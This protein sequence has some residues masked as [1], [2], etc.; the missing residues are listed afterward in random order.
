MTKFRKKPIVIEAFKWTGDFDQIE[1][2]EWAIKAIE[3]GIIY[4]IN[5]G[6][7]N[8]QMFII[9]SGTSNCQMFINTLEGVHE[10]SQGDWVIQGVKGELYPCKPD[11]FDLTYEAIND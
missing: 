11:I 10:V 4:F 9:N 2:P 1:D 3:S 6:T 7:S 5:S 8:C